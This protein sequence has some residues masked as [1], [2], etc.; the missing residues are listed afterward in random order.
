MGLVKRDVDRGGGT[1]SSILKVGEVGSIGGVLWL[2]F[3]LR[4]GTVVRGNSKGG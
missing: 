3:P 2:N 1:C 4:E